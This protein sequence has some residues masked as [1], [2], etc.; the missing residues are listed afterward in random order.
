MT[1][2]RWLRRKPTWAGQLDFAGPR[3][4]TAW[5]SWALLLLSLLAWLALADHADRLGTEREEAEAQI[6]RL[7]RADRLLRLERAVQLKA[8]A[9]AGPIGTPAPVLD[10]ASL[11]DATQ[12]AWR[13]AY[14][15]SAVLSGM[16]S[17]AAAQQVVLMS[18]SL[19][20]TAMGQAALRAQGA[21]RDD[22]AA[23]RW[24]AGLP[25]GQLLGRQALGAPFVNVRGSYALKA[26]VQAVWPVVTSPPGGV[27]P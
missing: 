4:R 8:S 9:S 20:L 14:P 5:W 23:L 27:T 25:Q 24:A 22:A 18:M 21:V 15:W 11:E 7:A 3:V 26:D 6:K 17:A 19:D 10:D 16:E 13:L 2:L 1:A 12:V